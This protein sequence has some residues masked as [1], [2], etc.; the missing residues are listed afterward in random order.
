MFIK[1]IKD[2]FIAPYENTT[3]TVRQKAR[4]FLVI[5]SVT[6]LLLFC[7]TIINLTTSASTHP[8]IISLVNLFMLLSLITGMILLR[9]GKYHSA[10]TLNTFIL[11]F[12][13]TAG[14]VFKFSVLLDK[15]FNNYT[16]F[17]FAVVAFSALFGKRKLQVAISLFFI[18]LNVG[19][20]LAAFLFFQPQNTGHLIGTTI[21]IIIALLLVMALSSQAT[22]ITDRA[23]S[24][25]ENELERNRS[26]SES[27]S[28]KIEE[29]ARTNE[30]L[31]QANEEL[32]AMYEE[33]HAMNEEM[34]TTSIELEDANEKLLI[35]KRFAEASANLLYISTLKGSV[36]YS[37]KS[38][39]EKILGDP[40]FDTT[41]IEVKKF[42]SDAVWPIV[43]GE[44]FSSVM[45]KGQWIGELP[46]L[47]KDNREI[48][49]IQNISLLTDS[50]NVP[51]YIATIITDISYQKHVERE[52]NKSENR[53]KNILETANEG[54][55]E[56]DND[57][58][59]IDANREL[60]KI[61]GCDREYII[62]KSISNFIEESNKDIF[63]SHW[64]LRSEGKASSYEL[65]MK[66]SD[67][68]TVPCLIKGTPLLNETGEKTGAFG[69]VTN[70]T[71]RKQLEMQLLLSQKMEAV[72][73]LAG[74][75]AHDFNNLLTAISGYSQLLKKQMEKDDSRIAYVDEIARAAERS[76]GLT[77]QLLAFSRRQMLK[78]SV[79]S[80]RHVI[81]GM[82]TMLNRIIGEN[83]DLIIKYSNDCFID[84]D[85]GQIEQ[86][87]MN[88]VINARDAMPAGGRIAIRIDSVFKDT[89]ADNSC[90]V[91]PDGDMVRI[92]ISDTGTGIEEEVLQKIFDPFFTTKESGEGT[93]LGL[94]VVYGIVQQHDGWVNVTS[95]PEEGTEFSI[96]L[97]RVNN[98]SG[99][100]IEEDSSGEV[101]QGEGERILLVEDQDEVRKFAT[102]ALSKY[103]YRVLE[104][105]S[106]TEARILFD[107]E[108]GD[109][110]V[111]F[112]DVVL[113]DGNGP[114]L[115]DEFREKKPDLKV[116][117]SSGYT[118]KKARWDHIVEKGYFF[119]PK[120]YS[121]ESLLKILKDVL[122]ESTRDENLKV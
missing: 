103:G 92:T 18:L 50:H 27:Y 71:D 56:I 10:V 95:E 86:I 25:T 80:I 19:F 46:V 58:V 110:D 17:M 49:A 119:L 42:Y 47:A 79:F 57:E 59:I 88:L 120:P 38:F 1:N 40:A 107:E 121:L 35:F 11:A 8:Y 70:L 61:F 76:G 21:N 2:Y 97:P 15:G 98:E 62:G 91:S 66:R 75:I 113:P 5:T 31:E 68:T 118:D 41:Q 115:V 101:G 9:K 52:V 93:G 13:V 109:F 4:V 26:L 65:L 44:I 29:L 108:E 39:N 51:S 99:C 111:V 22:S 112:S 100:M 64:L 84:A 20:L 87:V 122:E 106:I 12:G 104:V 23:L 105:A 28:V 114:D 30:D 33:Q 117:L 7:V 94:A 69:L 32:E 37:N 36:V 96:F 16:Y 67:G 74:G 24:G 77:K 73:T 81:K 45:E 60:C 85:Y 90:S 53:L 63:D 43:E 102:T 48:E 14:S 6:L 116:L 78:R 3:F 54:F 72:G 82:E 34:E 55:L 89:A 83:Y